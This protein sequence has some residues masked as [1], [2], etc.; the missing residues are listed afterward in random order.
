MTN[1]S[2]RYFEIPGFFAYGDKRSVFFAAG[3]IFR[4]VWVI[5][6]KKYENDSLSL[7]AARYLW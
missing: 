7:D 6:V 3:V 5:F 4:A 1:Y 2:N